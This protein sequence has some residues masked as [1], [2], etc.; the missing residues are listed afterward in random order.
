MPTYVQK[1]TNSDLSPFSAF[2]KEL[3]AGTGTD[4]SVTVS[5]IDPGSPVTGGFISPAG[6]PNSDQWEDSGT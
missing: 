3:S 2:N 6:V 5:G 1:S 4:A